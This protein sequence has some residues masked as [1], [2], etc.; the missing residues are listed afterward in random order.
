[1]KKCSNPLEWLQTT[2]S[3]AIQNPENASKVIATDTIISKLFAQR[4]LSD[5]HQQSL[6]TWNLLKNLINHAQSLPNGVE[7]I[8]EAGGAWSTLMDS[9]EKKRLC[10]VNES[11]YRTAKGKQCPQNLNKINATKPDTTAYMFPVPCGLTQGSSITIIGIPNGLLSNFRIDLT[12]EELPG[13]PDPPIILHY[14][15]R[16]HGDKLTEEPVIVQNTW[17]AAHDWGEEQRCPSPAPEK[18][19]KVDQLD[20]CS[21]I[22]VHDDKWFVMA[23]MHSNSSSRS[24]AVQEGSKT[25]KYFPFKQGYLSEATLRVGSEGIQMTVDGKHITSFAYRET[26][27]P[28]LISEVRISGDLQ[29]ISVLASGLPTSEDSSHTIDLEAL[30]SVSISLRKPI[31]LLIG[32]FSNTNNFKRRMAVRRTWMQYPAVRSGAVAV[33]FFVGLHKNKIVNEELWNEAQTYG[34]IQLMPFVDYYSL[35]TWKTLAICIFGTEVAL[36]KF[37]MKTDDDAFVRVDEVLASIKRVNVTH[38]LLYGLI[39]SDSRPHRSSDSKWYISPEEWLEETYPPWAHGPGYVVSNDIAKAI[40]K[41]HKKGHLKM[42][43]LEDVAMGIWIADIKKEGLE[44]LYENEGRVY[45]EGCKDGYVVAHYQGPREMLCLW[46]K[47]QEDKRA[48]C[49]GD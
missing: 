25:R 5:E 39:N 13:E 29:I 44:V 8:K 49:C 19:K 35:I 26:L 27:E 32:V 24:A 43:K 21:K 15:V 36:A 20:Q 38:G 14:N 47:L 22:V 16:L 3:N 7:A 37:V 23:N 10:Y 45:S 12:G 17:T 31:D 40:Y 41:T 46:Q 9:I 33:R 42:F 4:N 1:M 6:Q 2:A 28:W 48:K 30:K 18:I 34:D 11:A